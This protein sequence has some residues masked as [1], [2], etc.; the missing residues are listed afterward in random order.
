M[1]R[2]APRATRAATATQVTA[3]EA[4]GKLRKHLAAQELSVDALLAEAQ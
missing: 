3:S 2:R 4:W 1:V